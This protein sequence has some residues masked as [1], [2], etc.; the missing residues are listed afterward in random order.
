MVLGDY[1]PHTLPINA[2]AIMDTL[3]PKPFEGEK[4][5]R[6]SSR[7]KL[8][9]LRYS[10]GTSDVLCRDAKLRSTILTPLERSPSC[11]VH[12]KLDGPTKMSICA[13]VVARNSDHHSW[14][15]DL[16]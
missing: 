4:S 6:L 13:P 1:R 9:S 11:R 14:E 5:L 3:S 15:R 8:Q 2:D 10:T 12:T 16:N 7:K